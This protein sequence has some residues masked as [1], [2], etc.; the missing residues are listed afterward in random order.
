MDVWNNFSSLVFI[1]LCVT[2]LPMAFRMVS[3]VHK[4]FCHGSLP[5]G[6]EFEAVVLG[7]HGLITVT[8]TVS[9]RD[10]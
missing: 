5:P 6:D 8:V 9:S 1:Q 7:L 2:F 10:E 3:H 4:N